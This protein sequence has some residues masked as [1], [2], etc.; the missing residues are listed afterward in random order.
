MYE[1]FNA[2][3]VKDTVKAAGGRWNGE[4]K[5]WTLT[6]EQY[7]TLPEGALD[8]CRVLTDNV[9][10]CEM[11]ADATFR[12]VASGDRV[13]AQAADGRIY[14][15]WEK[16]VTRTARG[17]SSSY[18]RDRIAKGDLYEY[19]A[20]YAQG[21]ATARILDIVKAAL[22]Q[23]FRD[24]KWSFRQDDEVS[25]FEFVKGLVPGH[26]A[27]YGNTD[28]KVIAAVKRAQKTLSFKA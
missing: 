16:T 18:D 22:P 19:D 27:W 20:E 7:A 12:F 17:I 1:I 5:C 14:A 24:A 11:E 2:F 25:I 26:C 23:A 6:D 4:K 15:W 13:F 28:K 8:G 10:V 3:N 21:G 9:T